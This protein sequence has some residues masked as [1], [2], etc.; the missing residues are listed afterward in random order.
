MKQDTWR[1]TVEL[2]VMAGDMPKENV[3]SN[4][5]KILEDITDGTDFLGFNVI[6]AKRD[7]I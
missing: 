3:I 7:K 4:A 1:V 5:E 6:K 2:T